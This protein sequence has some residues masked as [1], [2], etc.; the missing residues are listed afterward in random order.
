MLRKSSNVGISKLVL[1][2]PDEALW[3]TYDRLGF[4][5]TTGSN[6]PGENS[7]T[8]VAPDPNKPFVKATMAFGYGLGVTSLQLARAYATLGSGGIRKP[9]NFLK[10]EGE[11]PGVRVLYTKVARDIV[12]MLNNVIENGPS[13]AKVP[14]YHVAGK[15]GTARKLGKDGYY[16]DS[17]HL[18]VFGGLAPAI[19]FKS[20]YC[21]YH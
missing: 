10:V 18:A 9:V 4:G 21:C 17:K 19:N 1:S 2:L 8:L 13:K 7:G 15:T 11:V 16:K 14:G 6:F 3:D 5:F 20:C 12:D